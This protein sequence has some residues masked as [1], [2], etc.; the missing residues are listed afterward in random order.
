MEQ[1]HRVIEAKCYKLRSWR[2]WLKAKGHPC[3]IPPKR[4]CDSSS[5]EPSLYRC[6]AFPSIC[7]YGRKHRQACPLQ[8]FLA[9][10][11]K[12]HEAPGQ[13]L[14]K[15]QS[16]TLLCRLRMSA[17]EVTSR[18]TPWRRRSIRVKKRRLQKDTKRRRAKEAV[19]FLY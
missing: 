11:P 8:E 9:S 15:D 3:N 12:V 7:I 5:E 1:Q 17:A 19:D 18:S 13:K 10:C 6:V 2:E 4:T 14:W 16:L